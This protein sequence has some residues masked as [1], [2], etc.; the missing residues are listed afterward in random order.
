MSR[1]HDF[2]LS[3]V[4]KAVLL[5]VPNWSSTVGQILMSHFKVNIPSSWK[6]RGRAPAP[7]Q[8]VRFSLAFCDEGRRM[9]RCGDQEEKSSWCC[10]GGWISC[11]IGLNDTLALAAG[12]RGH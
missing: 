3:L 10:R 1:R 8:H 9:S 7:R 2:D 12:V 5:L 4:L 6:T 11:Y